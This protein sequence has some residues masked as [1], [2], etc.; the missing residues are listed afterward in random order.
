[1]IRLARA[2]ALYPLRSLLLV[3]LTIILCSAALLILAPSSAQA[4]WL[5]HFF[6]GGSGELDFMRANT[7]NAPNAP[8]GTNTLPASTYLDPKPGS[9]SNFNSYYIDEKVN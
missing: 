7:P 9:T 3:L 4:R 8:S 5:R 1:M 2:A 6:D